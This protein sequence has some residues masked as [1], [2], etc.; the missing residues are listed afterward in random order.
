MRR[1]RQ[2]RDAT[3]PFDRGSHACVISSHDDRINGRGSGR[4][5][6]DMLDHRPA[7]DIGERLAGQ[8]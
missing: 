4:A 5:P 6:V 1:S 3:E 2:P 7:G 8:P